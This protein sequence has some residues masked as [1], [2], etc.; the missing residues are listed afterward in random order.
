F[1]NPSACSPGTVLLEPAPKQ[2]AQINAILAKDPV[3]NS[4][5]PMAQSID[6]AAADP[7]LHDASRRPS[8]LLVTDGWQWCSPYDAS[9]RTWPVDAVK[10]AVQKGIRVYVVG[11]GGDVD[12]LTLN[13]MASAAGTALAGCDPTGAMLAAA[14]KCYYQA[15]SAT[16]LNT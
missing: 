3:T 8:I 15:D 11:F 10:R 4:W 6:V 12:V 16:A 7:M 9:T 13:Q 14:N 1:P 5:T 2:G